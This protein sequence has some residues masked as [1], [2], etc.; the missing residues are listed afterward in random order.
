MFDQNS[1]MIISVDSHTPAGTTGNRRNPGACIGSNNLLLRTDTQNQSEPL[2]F[3][4]ESECAN[5]DVNVYN[6]DLNNPWNS[7]F[8]IYNY[9]TGGY[10]GTRNEAMDSRDQSPNSG[11]FS[12]TN[13]P[14]S[15]FQFEE[16]SGGLMIKQ[17]ALPG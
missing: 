11:Y 1:D 4:S 12:W 8:S 9:Q 6:K 5:L 13:Q 10:L 7:L 17:Y 16:A 3:V 15:V 14:V 2:A